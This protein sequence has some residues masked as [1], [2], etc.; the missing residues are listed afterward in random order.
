MCSSNI[1]IEF[2]HSKIDLNDQ[3]RKQTKNIVWLFSELNL[4][5]SIFTRMK[6]LHGWQ[7]NCRFMKNI[8]H[9]KQVDITTSRFFAHAYFRLG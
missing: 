1:Q 6:T 8:L 3:N 7:G 9:R 4:E 5:Y 2:F